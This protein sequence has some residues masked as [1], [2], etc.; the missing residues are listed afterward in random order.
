MSGQTF[1]ARQQLNSEARAH[2]KT[3]RMG[4]GTRKAIL[5]KGVLGGAMSGLESVRL[6]LDVVLRLV[7]VVL[8]H[9]PVF[10]RAIIEGCRARLVIAFEWLLAS[11]IQRRLV[12]AGCNKVGRDSLQK[13]MPVEGGLLR[14]P[15]VADCALPTPI[16]FLGHK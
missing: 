10:P 9:M 13:L 4:I 6:L 11:A 14:K 7:V 8:N 2:V 1:K 3:N 15:F 5:N 12:S 16:Q